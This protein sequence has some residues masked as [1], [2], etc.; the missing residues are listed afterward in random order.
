MP[1]AYFGPV[2]LNI[3]DNDTDI[4]FLKQCFEKV[5]ADDLSM[6]DINNIMKSLQYIDLYSQFEEKCDLLESK[7]RTS[8]LWIAYIR[9]VE[10]DKDFIT[11]ERTSS[12]E[13]HLYAV[14]KI[15][16]LFAAA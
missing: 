7:S 9:Y 4:K 5:L 14:S 3:D 2:S 15:L 11:A 12:W 13:L 6:D 16:N 8:K 1:W 10:K